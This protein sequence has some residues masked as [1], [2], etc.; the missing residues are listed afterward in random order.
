M[1]I[2]REVEEMCVVKQGVH[3]GAAPI[4]EEA[5]CGGGVMT[6]TGS[7]GAFM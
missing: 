1:V 3:H 5:K 7:L 4:P 2:S 6:T